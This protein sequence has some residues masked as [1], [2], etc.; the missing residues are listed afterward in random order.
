MSDLK[1]LFQILVVF[2][3]RTRQALTRASFF[4]G[5]NKAEKAVLL[6]TYLIVL[7]QL[8][9]ART[10]ISGIQAISLIGASCIATVIGW[11]PDNKGHIFTC[12][13]QPP[14]KT[15]VPSSFQAE[16]KTCNNVHGFT[17]N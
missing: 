12:L 5:T 11:P 6:S 1:V 14:E 16:H 9:V 7:S 10:F 4:I 15:V 2:V 8:P 17:N 13:S 3:N